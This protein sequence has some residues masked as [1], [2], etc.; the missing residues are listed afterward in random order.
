MHCNTSNQSKWHLPDFAP[1]PDRPNIMYPDV[2]TAFATPW[3]QGHAPYS[4]NGNTWRHAHYPPPQHNLSIFYSLLEHKRA[5]HQLGC[6]RMC[7]ERWSGR[8]DMRH[9]SETYLSMC[10]RACYRSTSHLAWAS[11]T[12]PSNTEAAESG[13]LAQTSRALQHCAP[14]TPCCS[15]AVTCI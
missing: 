11:R 13:Q 2:C 9:L 15:R 14:Q 3:W 7:A 5:F 10:R 1:A 12:P 8:P 6:L 4:C